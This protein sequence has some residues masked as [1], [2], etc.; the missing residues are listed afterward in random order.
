MLEGIKVVALD[1]D[2]TLAIHEVHQTG[3]EAD[4]LPII[5]AR[6]TAYWEDKGTLPSIEMQALLDEC[7]LRDIQVGLISAIGFGA[8]QEVK[9]DWVEENYGVRLHNWC[10]PTTADKPSMLKALCVKYG[11]AKG[12]ILFV[13]DRTP[14]LDEASDLGYKVATPMQVVNAFRQKERKQP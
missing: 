10:T 13:D 14:I 12:E 8:M 5:Y 1:F 11:V 3:E 2:D 6:G 4:T 9:L 7:Q